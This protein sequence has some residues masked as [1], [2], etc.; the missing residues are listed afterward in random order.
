V[1]AAHDSPVE[2]R[3]S[4]SMT[5]KGDMQQFFFTKLIKS[6]FKLIITAI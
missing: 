6:S 2:Q 1:E 3:Q 4:S 5:L